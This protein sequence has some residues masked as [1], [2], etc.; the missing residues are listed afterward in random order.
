MIHYK[1]CTSD[2]ALLVHTCDPCGDT[3][4]GRV[5][6]VALVV[7]GT[8]LSIPF[9]KQ[10]WESLI[11]AGL[12][13]VIPETTGSS[14]GGSPV[15][16][17]GYGDQDQRKIADEYTLPFKDP[18][19]KQNTKFWEAA[20]KKK[21]NLLYRTETQLHYVKDKVSITAKAPVEEDLASEVVWNVEA[22]WKGKNKPVNSDLEPVA[23]FFN[24]HE[25]IDGSSASSSSS[26]STAAES[27]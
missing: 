17:P 14:D 24:C 10:E 4:L 9:N 1:K 8:H 19:Y 25:V 11:E 12:L 15:Y 5:R 26:G 13:I 3:E 16:G 18:A 27:N 20:E 22:K 7:A 6:G 23:E 2:G 21:W